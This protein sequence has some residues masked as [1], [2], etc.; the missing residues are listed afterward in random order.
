MTRRWVGVAALVLAACSSSPPRPPQ[1][2]AGYSMIY[3]QSFARPAA[4]E[5]LCVSDPGAFAV[6]V[7]TDGRSALEILRPSRYAPPVRSPRAIALVQYLLVADFVLEVDVQ[8][9]GREYAHRDACV[10]FGFEAPDRFYYVHLASRA[11]QHAHGVFLVDR[12]PRRNVT[13]RRTHGVDWGQ[14]RWRHVVV[15]RD[16]TTGEIRVWVD[17]SERPVLEAREKTLRLG[18]VGLGSFDDTARFRNLRL[19]APRW[20]YRPTECFGR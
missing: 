4:L 1:V 8:Q 20:V 10:F 16:A 3:E 18:Q 13:A 7:G 11:D 6:R 17:G 12:A 14:G 9:T 19:W 2:P 15:A 5:E